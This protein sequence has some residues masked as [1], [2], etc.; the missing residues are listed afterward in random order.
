[1]KIQLLIWCE[2]T[3]DQHRVGYVP[4]WEDDPNYIREVQQQMDAGM[5]LCDCSNCNP[6]GSESVMEALSMAT[7]DNFDD[8]L[9]NT[10]TGPVNVDLTPKYPPRANN[11]MK[12]K[13][14]EDDKAEIETF[15]KHL[16][17]NLHNYYD[18]EISPDGNLRGADLF[19]ADDCVA[20]LSHMGNIVE[21]KYLKK[22]IGAECF[23]GLARPP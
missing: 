10:Y 14:T 2:F 13:F 12:R 22:I 11:P 17:N 18:T 5:P 3:I 4:L 9:Q 6:A 21:P 16:S 8:I 15:T 19:D 7:K 20:I 1:M 23:E